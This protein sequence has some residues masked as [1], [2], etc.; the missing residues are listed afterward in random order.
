MARLF[1]VANGKMSLGRKFAKAGGPPFLHSHF[2]IP[3]NL[4]RS[5]ASNTTRP[6]SRLLPHSLRVPH[7]SAPLR[8]VGVFGV[9]VFGVGVGFAPRSLPIL[10][11]RRAQT[12]FPIL[13]N[14]QSPPRPRPSHQNLS[15]HS[16]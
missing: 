7:P 8:R 10:N 4:Q 16:L 6:F 5:R 3:H 9:G 11:I 15:K 14:L 2:V 12:L 13:I 1:L